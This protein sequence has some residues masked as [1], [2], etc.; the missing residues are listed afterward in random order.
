MSDTLHQKT[1]SQNL[2]THTLGRS[3]MCM[4]YERFD[5]TEETIE[6]LEVTI[7]SDDNI[8]NNG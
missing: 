3:P 5:C 1:T 2:I 4:G 7:E 8:S 6:V